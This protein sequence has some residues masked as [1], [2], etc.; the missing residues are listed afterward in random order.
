[1]ETKAYENFIELLSRRFSCRKYSAEPVGDDL[2][3]KVVEAARL[4]PSACN[5]QPWTFIVAP[6]GV[7]ARLGAL[8][9]RSFVAETPTLIVAVGHH[10]EAWHRTSTDGKDHTDIDLAIAIEHLCLAA[11]TLGLQTCWVCNFNAAEAARILGLG[12]S[13]EVVALVPIGFPAEEEP[14]KKR[15]PLSDILRR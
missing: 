1:M 2:I 14:A 13:E 7:R 3:E 11:T 15:K 10:D 5:R 4:A 12:E 8:C 9:S 6:D